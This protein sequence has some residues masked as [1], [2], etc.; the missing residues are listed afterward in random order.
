MME[1][2]GAGNGKHAKTNEFLKDTHLHEI[3]GGT[4]EMEWI[5]RIK[6]K[7]RCRVH[8]DSGSFRVYGCLAAPVHM[9]PDVIPINQEFDFYLQSNYDVYLLRLVNSTVKTGDICPAGKDGIIYI[10]CRFPMQKATLSED[11]ETVLRALEPF[12]FPSLHNPKHGITFEI[13]G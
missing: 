6:R 7:R 4:T 5:E 12:G 2:Q 1:K 9:I 13:E 10:I 8:F 3:N 11:I